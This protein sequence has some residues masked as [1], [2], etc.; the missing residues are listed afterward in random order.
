MKLRLHELQKANSKASRLRQQKIHSY[1]E[2]NE[3]FYYQSL[4]FVAKTIQTEL[5]N[6]HHDDFLAGYLGTKKTCELLVQKYYWPI[7]RHNI[8]AYLCKRLWHL[9]SLKSSPL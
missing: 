8:K 5:I 6:R 2:I 9:Y 4:F 3:I 7:L 1:K